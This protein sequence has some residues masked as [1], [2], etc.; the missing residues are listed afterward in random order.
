[1]TPIHRGQIALPLMAILAGTLLA[2]ARFGVIHI[3]H[4]RDLWPIGFIAFGLEDLAVRR[5]PE[6]ARS[7]PE[8]HR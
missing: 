1:M 5:V 3:A 6:R 2:M 7:F 4:L 8:R